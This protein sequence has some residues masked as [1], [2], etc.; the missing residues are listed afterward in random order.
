[1]FQNKCEKFYF[2]GLKYFFNRLSFKTAL[3]QEF[4]F[5]FHE[6]VLKQSIFNCNFKVWC[7]CNKNYTFL[8]KP[9][10]KNALSEHQFNGHQQ[11]LD[12]KRQSTCVNRWIFR[13]LTWENTC[14]I[15]FFDFKAYKLN[16]MLFCCCSKNWV[17]SLC[18]FTHDCQTRKLTNWLFFEKSAW[19]L[20]SATKSIIDC[21]KQS[22]ITLL[23]L[24]CNKKNQ[25]QL[26][27][28]KSPLKSKNKKIPL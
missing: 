25:C 27:L 12:Q 28:F 26:N 2:C 7:G 11:D 19:S 21:S 10:P 17:S 1:M 6:S 23:K 16:E 14:L 5:K 4:W 20:L 15:T 8:E 3:E 13:Q 24:V 22:Q 18:S 9:W